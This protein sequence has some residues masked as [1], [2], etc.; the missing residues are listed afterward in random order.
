M[1]PA[2][3]AAIVPDEAI[4]IETAPAATVMEIVA[5]TAPAGETATIATETVIDRA[6]VRLPNRQDGRSSF[7]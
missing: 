7:S 3:V 4:A 2:A 6:A 5:V 1:S